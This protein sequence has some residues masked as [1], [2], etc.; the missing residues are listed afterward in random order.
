MNVINTTVRQTITV[1][2]AHH[3]AINAASDAEL[4]GYDINAG[5]PSNGV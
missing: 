1:E 2:R 4:Y 5:W 3:E